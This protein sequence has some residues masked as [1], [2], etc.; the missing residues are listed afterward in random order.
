MEIENMV[1]ECDV[2][3]SDVNVKKDCRIIGDCNKKK[4]SYYKFYFHYIKVV[5]G[6]VDSV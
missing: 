2:C 4:K 1:F 5:I 3:L 6:C